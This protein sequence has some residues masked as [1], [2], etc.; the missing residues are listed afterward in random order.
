M[1]FTW[2]PGCGVIGKVI[3]VSLLRLLTTALDVAYKTTTMLPFFHS[4]LLY[5]HAAD[6]RGFLDD[7]S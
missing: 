4:P 5:D 1:D 7:N 2:Q 3:G 6:A